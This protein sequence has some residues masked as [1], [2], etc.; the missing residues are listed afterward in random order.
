MTLKLRI[1]VFYLGLWQ[2]SDNMCNVIWTQLW[3]RNRITIL[4][5]IEI[6]L[7]RSF[8]FFW[9]LLWC[10]DVSSEEFLYFKKC[11]NVIFNPHLNFMKVLMFFESSHII[12]SFYIF[13][14]LFCS[15]VNLLERDWLHGTIRRK[16]RS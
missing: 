14:N 15:S 8:L 16:C 4:E 11:L 13:C 1:H 5:A 10:L 12:N 7:S 9:I 6:S 2:K 3:W